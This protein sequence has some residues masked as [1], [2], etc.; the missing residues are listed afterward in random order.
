MASIR[1]P[2]TFFTKMLH[3]AFMIKIT[4]SFWGEKG[5]KCF[6]CGQ[7]SE[8]WA[9]RWPTDT[10]LQIYFHRTGWWSLA[11]LLTRMWVS[12]NYLTCCCLCFLPKQYRAFDI[13]SKR[14]WGNIFLLHAY[15]KYSFTKKQCVHKHAHTQSTRPILWTESC[16]FLLPPTPKRLAGLQCLVLMAVLRSNWPFHLCLISDGGTEFF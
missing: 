10:R 8:C 3:K 9:L 6:L 13:H 7:V 14:P 5:D 16:I 15:N 12:L 2:D 11:F 1:K 4:L